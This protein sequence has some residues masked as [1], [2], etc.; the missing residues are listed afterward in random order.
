MTFCR[1]VSLGRLTNIFVPCMKPVGFARNLSRS[2]SS[3]VRSAFFIAAEKSNPGTVP[4]LLPAMPARDGP[5]LFSPGVV[6]WH[7]AQWAA[8]TF[9][10][11]AGSPAANAGD[12]VTRILISSR[13]A[14]I[15]DR[16]ICA[17]SRFPDVSELGLAAIHQE[18]AQ[19]AGLNLRCGAALA[20]SG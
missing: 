13:P 3:Q 8:N 17:R 9:S 12:D 20:L 16:F 5:T 11:A 10:P 15:R 18:S 1:S 19:S 2:A 6:A 4:L 14:L 7:T